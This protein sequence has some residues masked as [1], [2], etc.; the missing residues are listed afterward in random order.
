MGGFD[1]TSRIEG[2]ENNSI[3]KGKQNE[4]KKAI[5]IREETNDD[6]VNAVEIRSFSRLRELVEDGKINVNAYNKKGWT[7]LTAAV[8]YNYFEGVK[9]LVEHGADVNLPNGYGWTPVIVA[10]SYGRIK[11]LK[12]LIEKGADIN[13]KDI[14]NWDAF[15][16]AALFNQEKVVEY[17]VSINH[18]PQQ[19]EFEKIIKV[20]KVYSNTRMQKML[21]NIY[22]EHYGEIKIRE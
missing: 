2:I 10:A 15:M 16:H 20:S 3:E 1:K 11:I 8:Y 18:I 7:P 17:F 12:Y 6:I 14:T 19:E 21:L 9:Y 13:A 22:R 5:S 4:I